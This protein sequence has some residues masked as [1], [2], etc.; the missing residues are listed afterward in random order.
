MGAGPGEVVALLP[1]VLNFRILW[2]EASDEAASFLRLSHGFASA[3]VQLQVLQA[4][5]GSNGRCLSSKFEV[6]LLCP[7]R[8][9]LG[10]LKRIPA[11]SRQRRFLHLC[12]LPM[13]HLGLHPGVYETAHIKD[14]PEPE[15]MAEEPKETS[16]KVRDLH[17]SLG[18]CLSRAILQG[19][20]RLG[21]RSMPHTPVLMA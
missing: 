9:F 14:G 15:A 4:A 10:C 3:A 12:G 1:D 21:S 6:Y 13:W 18:M 11:H 16:E 2:S 5:P 20:G 7:R 8:N 19:S 17:R